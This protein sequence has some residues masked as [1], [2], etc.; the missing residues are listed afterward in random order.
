VVRGR[1][2]R[3]ILRGQEVYED[4][5]VLAPPGFG[6]NVRQVSTTQTS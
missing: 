6:R 3:V 2:R 1:V 5:R 4:G